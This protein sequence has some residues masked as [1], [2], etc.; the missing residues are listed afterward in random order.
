MSNKDSF[1]YPKMKRVLWPT[2][3][4]IR[5]ILEICWVATIQVFWRTHQGIPVWCPFLRWADRLR[6][7]RRKIQHVSSLVFKKTTGSF[8]DDL[9][10]PTDYS[11]IAAF[12][13][14]IL[15]MWEL[16]SFTELYL[17]ADHRQKHKTGWKVSISSNCQI[18]VWASCHWF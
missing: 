16:I 17:E 3:H 10:L 11:S 5:T 1:R 15:S 7:E 9:I 4:T 13:H 18:C 12:S 6:G 2:A 8:L 14:T